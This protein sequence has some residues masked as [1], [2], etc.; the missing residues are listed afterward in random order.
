MIYPYDKLYLYDVMKNMAAMFDVAINA[1][2]LDPDGFAALFADSS[3]A[4]KIENAIPDMLAGK[5]G[6][7]M[8][9]IILSKKVDFCVIPMDRT[10]E[11]WAGWILAIAQW[12]LNLPFKKILEAIPFSSIIG[13]YHPYHEADESKSIEAIR[14]RLPAK[15]NGLKLMR[16]KRKLTQEQLA[17]L[18]GVNIRSIR[19]Y[20]QGENDI[21]KA[22]VGTLQMLSSAL[23]CNIEDLI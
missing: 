17:M 20:E 18:S 19:S 7:E 16:K 3:V 8:L 1:E 13:M 9:S 23:Y 10:P 15:E 4:R 2:G 14:E 21:L 6:I 12:E 5:S 11:Y 22:R